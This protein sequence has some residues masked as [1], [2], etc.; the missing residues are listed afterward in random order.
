[1]AT[2]MGSR[3]NGKKCRPMTL[4]TPSK[5]FSLFFLQNYGPRMSV[6]FWPAIQRTL[7]QFCTVDD[8]LAAAAAKTCFIIAAQLPLPYSSATTAEL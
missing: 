5:G 2:I 3:P 6:R 4:S 8:V 7:L 1:M